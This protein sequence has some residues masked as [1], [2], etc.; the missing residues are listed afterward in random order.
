VPS[1]VRKNA[2]KLELCFEIYAKN[3]KSQFFSK[4]A[5]NIHGL[6]L[7]LVPLCQ[8]PKEERAENFQT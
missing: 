7:T 8:M 3:E 6:E 2:K 4:S 5:K 1:K